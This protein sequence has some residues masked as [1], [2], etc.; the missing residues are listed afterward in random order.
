MGFSDFLRSAAA[1]FRLSKKSDKEEFALYLKL[2][3]LGIIVIGTIGF[4]IK[5]AGNIFFG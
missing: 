1:I 2:V 4:I 3:G 5:L